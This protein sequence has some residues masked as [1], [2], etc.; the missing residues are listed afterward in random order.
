MYLISFFK[1]IYVKLLIIFEIINKLQLN[2]L[3]KNK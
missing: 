1:E 2:D 3:L